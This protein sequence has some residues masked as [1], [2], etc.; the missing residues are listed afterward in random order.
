[1]SWF[2]IGAA[3]AAPV[4]GKVF[5]SSSGSKKREARKDRHF[6][7]QMLDKTQ[8]NTRENIVLGNDMDLRNQQQMF[9]YRINQ[10]VK[11]GMT[12]YEMYMGPAAGAGGGTS[13]TGA[14]LGNAANQRGIA[15]SQIAQENRRTERLIEQESNQ[16]N[17]D[18][19]T[20]I[21]KTSMQTEAQKDVA[22]TQAGVTTR[23]QDLQ[24]QI[25]DNVLSLNQRE[26]E[27]IKLPQA[28]AQLGL[29]KQQLQTEINKTA[30]SSE[31]FQTLIKQLSMGPA[32]LLV[33][34]T[35]RS[36]GISL[37]DDSFQKLTEAKRKQILQELLAMS[38]SLYT[39]TA[40]ATTAIREPIEQ[41]GDTVADWISSLITS[42]NEGIQPTNAPNPVL[43]GAP[44]SRVSEP[45]LGRPGTYEGSKR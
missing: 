26:L 25:A 19:V 27:E 7:E 45:I 29:T 17:A 44:G 12:P 22:E 2:D 6:Q 10:G 24:K 14:T 3:V 43:G 15:A 32:N 11:A 34:L 23:G 4:L 5:G 20:E 8:K 35:M 28:G 30:T 42:G 39:E 18:R 9:D 31:K 41:V 1:M 37:S 16:R 21:L 33:E 40:G 36:H 38:S 13:N